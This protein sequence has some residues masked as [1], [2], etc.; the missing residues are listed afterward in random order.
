MVCEFHGQARRAEQTSFMADESSQP[1]TE[2]CTPVSSS[3]YTNVLWRSRLVSKR[4][5][6]A[7]WWAG[8]PL[9]L[10]MVP[11]W[12]VGR[13]FVCDLLNQQA[14]PRRH[15]FGCYWKCQSWAL[16]LND[17]EQLEPALNKAL[18]QDTGSQKATGLGRFGLLSQTQAA[19][20][21]SRGRAMQ[22]MGTRY[23]RWRLLIARS[24]SRLSSGR[25]QILNECR[26]LSEVKKR[27][28]MIRFGALGR[29]AA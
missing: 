23:F 4:E 13:I 26:W 17:T 5:R 12:L 10:G 16:Q 11:A 9:S 28:N 3:K 29:W 2:L 25:L 21:P 19:V 24:C 1:S 15:E 18:T 27:L 20:G 22:K 7:V 14:Q 6:A 8:C